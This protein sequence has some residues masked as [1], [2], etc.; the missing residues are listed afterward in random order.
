MLKHFP[1][2]S[3]S[4]PSHLQL[5]HSGVQTRTSR[6]RQAPG[7]TSRSA[8]LRWTSARTESCSK[9]PAPAAW[10]WP[11]WRLWNAAACGSVPLPSP[12]NKGKPEDCTW[13]TP[14]PYT[15]YTYL[16]PIYYPWQF[17]EEVKVRLA[18]RPPQPQSSLPLPLAPFHSTCTTLWWPVQ[19]LA[20]R[21]QG[22]AVFRHLPGEQEK[23]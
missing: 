7:N 9:Q 8:S 5:D 15:Q 19:C 22:Y 1:K 18:N 21:A 14:L 23:K 20:Q 17:P 11:G 2:F 6:Y 13:T 3:S 12:T 16:H 10:S 4:Q